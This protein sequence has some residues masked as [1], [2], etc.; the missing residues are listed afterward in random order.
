V[1]GWLPRGAHDWR[2]F[3]RPSE[4]ARA[5]RSGGLRIEGLTGVVYD[6]LRDRFRLSRD[7]AVNYMLFA[8]RG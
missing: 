1:L 4:A 3:V 8:T 7:P 2:R 5:L 6:P